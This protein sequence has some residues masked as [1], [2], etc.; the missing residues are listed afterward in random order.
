MNRLLRVAAVSCAGSLLCACRG[1]TIDF[2]AP[3]GNPDG[4]PT[5][6]QGGDWQLLPRAEGSVFRTLVGSGPTDIWGATL[7]NSLYHYDGHGWTSIAVQAPANVGDIP[8]QIASA[9]IGTLWI[10]NSYGIVLVDASGNQTDY[11]SEINPATDAVLIDSSAD[12]VVVALPAKNK[13]FS[14]NGTDFVP[15]PPTSEYAISRLTV[16][17]KDSV[18]LMDE[19]GGGGYFDGDQWRLTDWKTVGPG[20]LTAFSTQR[21][22][23]FSEGGTVC[24]DWCHAGYPPHGITTTSPWQGSMACWP[25]DGNCGRVSN[26]VM[27]T[28][29]VSIDPPADLDPE[30]AYTGMMAEPAKS[31]NLALLGC[32]YGQTSG[33]TGTWVVYEWSGQPGD[34]PVRRTLSSSPE[35]S[36]GLALAN[37]PFP[38]LSPALTDGTWILPTDSDGDPSDPFTNAGAILMRP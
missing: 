6:A 25:A 21:A 37:A 26:S 24:P 3:S 35:C 38:V 23:L 14:F 5:I 34:T 17:S 13:V 19:L 18:W 2:G 10:A 33:S 16:Q 7:G 9:G 31:G 30:E 11:T 20:L 27:N 36:P 32:V 8:G 4:S 22:V 28:V 1:Q 29:P 15:M 12:M